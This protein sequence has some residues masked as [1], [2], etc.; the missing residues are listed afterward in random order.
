MVHYAYVSETLPIHARVMISQSGMMTTSLK[1][2][3][4][5]MPALLQASHITVSHWWSAVVMIHEGVC[6]NAQHKNVT[7]PADMGQDHQEPF[8]DSNY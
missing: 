4:E 8:I 2:F 5:S 6:A 7:D 3:L 1:T